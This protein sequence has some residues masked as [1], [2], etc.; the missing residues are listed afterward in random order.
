MNTTLHAITRRLLVF[1]GASFGTFV[2][3]LTVGELTGLT[4]GTP[5]E[6]ASSAELALLITKAV[7]ILTAG[8]GIAL[9]LLAFAKRGFTVPS[10]RRS[11]AAGLAC[12]TALELAYV[13]NS[14]V[15][16]FSIRGS[17]RLVFSTVVSVVICGYRARRPSDE[18]ELS[19]TSAA[20]V[21]A[22][23]EAV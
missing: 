16:E 9:R 15:S 3:Y 17:V 14:W 18:P 10:L 2:L 21:A 4:A 20:V 6:Y 8:H 1:A 22:P 13:S 11:A 12:A 23:A 5:L 7:V 19:P